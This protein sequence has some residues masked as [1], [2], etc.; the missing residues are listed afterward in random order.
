MLFRR[1][2]EQRKKTLRSRIVEILPPEAALVS[3][4]CGGIFLENAEVVL[5]FA[6]TRHIFRAN[7]GWIYHN[8]MLLCSPGYLYLEKE[9][10]GSKLIQMIQR[11]WML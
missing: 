2:K 5:E 3:L 6:K 9:D 10:T 7:R 11:Q 4:D 1:K 8:G